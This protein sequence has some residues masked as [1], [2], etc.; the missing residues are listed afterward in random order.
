MMRKVLMILSG[1]FFLTQA[2]AFPCYITMIKDS[3]WSNYNVTVDIVDLFT[4]KVMVTMTMPKGK[5]W[6]RKEI[7]CQP[8]QTVQLR[9]TYTPTFWAKD[10]GKVHYG[11]RHWSFPDEVKKGDAAWNMTLCFAKDIAEAS[12]PPES[13]GQC[14]CET[15]GIPEIEPR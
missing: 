5:S 1:V 12:L 15:K 4:N 3:C 14:I 7:V 11:K 10:A 8:K 9:A 2:Q 13:S 6:D